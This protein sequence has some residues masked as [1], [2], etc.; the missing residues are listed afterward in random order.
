[1]H[2]GV[3]REQR[4]L[5]DV[6]E[7]R[8]I[9]RGESRQGVAEQVVLPVSDWSDRIDEHETSHSVAIA[10]RREHR[11]AAAPRVAEDVPL[12]ETNRLADRREVTSV[13]L[14]SGSSSARRN[15]RRTSSALV[16]QNQLPS[17]GERCERWPE[18]VMIEQQAAVH[19]D[20]RNGTVYF[21]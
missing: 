8:A 17:L 18:Q 2:G 6:L 3:G 1:V 11:E 12:R 14:D 7:H 9:A 4:G 20:K 19:A 5:V 10:L 15:L 16:V 21:W 13:V